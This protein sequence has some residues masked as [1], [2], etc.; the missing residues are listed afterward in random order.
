MFHF[1]QI[2]IVNAHILLKE[3]F[4]LERNDNN[5]TLLI[6]MEN[7]VE[8]IFSTCYKDKPI[9]E[10]DGDEEV[11]P[12]VVK[13]ASSSNFSR[14][15]TIINTSNRLTGNHF[16]VQYETRNGPDSKNNRRRCRVCNIK[17]RVKCNNS[18]CD[19]ALCINDCGEEPNCWAKFHK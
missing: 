5:F 10:V 1:V 2:S 13:N 17:S 4:K 19:V 11:E 8:E 3:T 18:K 12:L 16:H 6:F 9:I 15:N 14:T 7:L